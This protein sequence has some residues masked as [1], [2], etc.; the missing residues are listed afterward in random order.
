[1]ENDSP[2]ARYS[3][4]LSQS[5]GTAKVKS[6]DAQK[7]L[8][9]CRCVGLVAGP[10]SAAF[11]KS[12]VQIPATSEPTQ[13]AVFKARAL[14]SGWID[15]TPHTDFGIYLPVK[16]NGHNAMALLTAS[17]TSIGISSRRPV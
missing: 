2:L 3:H 4:T 5:D 12:T 17:Q 11:A 15:F 14:S 16:I 9:A 13:T 1:M 7:S 8:L 6:I 10:L